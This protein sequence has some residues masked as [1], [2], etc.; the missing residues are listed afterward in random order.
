MGI[1]PSGIAVAV[2]RAK[3]RMVALEQELNE[4][5]SKLGDGDTG[6][7]LTRL[8]DA[9]SDSSVADERDAGAA[10]MALARSG[11]ACTG[12][13]LG[14][15]IVTALMAMAKETRGVA[16]ADWSEF[17]SLAS[18][19]CEAMMKRGN[20]ELGA[21]TVIDAVDYLARGIRGRNTLDE[22]K[23]NAVGATQKALVDFRDAPCKTGRARMF[24][25][26]SVGLDDPGMLALAELVKAISGI[27]P[28]NMASV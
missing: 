7:M 19:A 3:A 2:E 15:L 27:D 22:I 14:T 24:A 13:S 11:A 5:D 1:T 4:A 21:K 8:I 23:A 28:G 17:G 6:G 9:F 18:I 10:F 26:R 20:T 25:E 12:S 16:D